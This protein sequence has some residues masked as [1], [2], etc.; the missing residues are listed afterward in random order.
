MKGERPGRHQVWT[1]F[2]TLRWD[3]WNAGFVFWLPCHFILL[4]LMEEMPPRGSLRPKWNRA[5]QA[6]GCPIHR[7]RKAQTRIK[8]NSDSLRLHGLQHTRL[9]CPLPTPRVCSNSYSSSLWCNPTFSSSVVPFSPCLQSSPA[10]GS[11]PIS[12]FFTSSGQSIGVSASAP[13]FPTN[14]RNWFP[15][16]WTGVIPLQS[17]GLSGV[18]YSTTIHSKT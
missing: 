2:G 3:I 9:P 15:L 11:F 1:S 5:Q 10:S 4:W 16:G 17:N 6:W 7:D 8:K 13:V 18:F 14:I 12:P